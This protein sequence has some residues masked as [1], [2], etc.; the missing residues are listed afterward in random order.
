MAPARSWPSQRHAARSRTGSSR[1]S[2][3]RPGIAKARGAG[4]GMRTGWGDV[5]GPPVDRLLPRP[6]APPAPVEAACD[7]RQWCVK[8]R[9]VPV[10]D[11]ECR[12]PTGVVQRRGTEAVGRCA[13]PFRA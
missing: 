3:G 4:A 10:G 6:V 13:V 9:S 8:R 11:G 1:S 2:S 7:V 5:P 12:I